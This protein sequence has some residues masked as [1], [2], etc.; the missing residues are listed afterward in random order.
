M[1]T[2]GAWLRREPRTCGWQAPDCQDRQVLVGAARRVCMRHCEDCGRVY[3]RDG[4][5]RCACGHALDY[6]EPPRPTAGPD[7]TALDPDRGLWA[8]ESFLPT[9]QRVTLGEVWT[10]LIELPAFEATFKCEFRHPTGSFKDRGAATVVSEALAVGADRVLEDS[11]GNAGLAVASYAARAGLDATVY[12][13]TD[14]T[15]KK[16]RRIERTG[17]DVVAIEGDRQAVTEACVDAVENGDGWY[18][19]HAWNPAFLAGT[20]T[21][22]YELAAQRGWSVPDAVVTPLGHGTLLLGAY[23]GFRA[24][25]E[26]GWTDR[27]PALFGAQAAGASPIADDLHGPSAGQNALADGIQIREPVRD[28]QIRAALDATGGD[29]IALSESATRRAHDRLARAGIHVEPTCATALA[30]LQTLR[31]RGVDPGADVVVALTG[32]NG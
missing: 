29:A 6:Q 17:A 21:F 9:A 13:P 8:F 30:A 26:A 14:A 22:A 27:M 20:A 19:S 11:S 28:D 18:A 23:R 32:R 2:K 16:R 3:E 24:L 1:Q 5:W 12:V 31:E 4:P 10:P 7:E 15:P 25:H